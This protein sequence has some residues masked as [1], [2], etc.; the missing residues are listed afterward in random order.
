MRLTKPN[1]KKLNMM[2]SLD[3]RSSMHC[4][5]PQMRHD[6]QGKNIKHLII[7]SSFPDVRCQER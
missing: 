3:M 6:R 4:A 5:E 2:V 1:F 7:Y